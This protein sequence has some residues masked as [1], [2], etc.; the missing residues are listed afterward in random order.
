MQKV[1]RRASTGLAAA[2]LAAAGGVV[3]IAADLSGTWSASVKLSSGQSGTPTFILKQT[4]QKLSG[5]YSGRLGSAP[6]SGT[7]TGSKVHLS[8]EIQGS[9]I[10]YAGTL[11]GDGNAM[12][13]SVDYAGQASGTFTATRR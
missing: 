3:A 9:T 12:Q 2:I 11:A 5:T 7:V 8:F 4:G 1:I 6:V 10:R 13:G